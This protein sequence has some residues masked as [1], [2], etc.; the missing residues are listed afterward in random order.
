MAGER[1]ETRS[2]KGPA[3]RRRARIA[4]L[5]TALAAGVLAA[6]LLASPFILLRIGPV[7]DAALDLA[8]DQA[9]L[10]Q[11]LRLRIARVGSLDPTRVRLIGVSVERRE[12]AGDW[13]RVLGVGDLSAS[14]DPLA[15][16]RRR[17]HIHAVAIDSV[18]A[19]LAGTG[20]E[21]TADLPA[22]RRI[23]PL[24][25]A[26]HAVGLVPS[27]AVDAVELTRIAVRDSAGVFVTGGLRLG[28]LRSS[29]LGLAGEVRGGE[30]GLPRLGLEGRLGRGSLHAGR[31]G[32]LA[33]RG[34]RIELGESAAVLQAGFDPGEKDLPLSVQL[35]IEMFR[36]APWARLWPAPLSG[37]PDDYLAGSVD[38]QAGEERW[39]ALAALEGRLLGE[40][41]EELRALV[42]AEGPALELR[43]LRLRGDAGA[44]AGSGRWDL[45]SRRG[46]ARLEWERVD[47]HSAWLPWLRELPLQA[48]VGGSARVEARFPAGEDPVI[49]GEL[50]VRGADPW[51]V[52]VS[53]CR[54]AASVDPARGIEADELELRLAGGSLRGQ[55]E[56]PLDGRPVRGLV[57]VDSLDLG[58]LPAAWSGGAAGR[59]SGAVSLSGPPHA[60][61][62]LGEAQGLDLRWRDWRAD[63]L[64]VER[65]ELDLATLDGS[66]LVHAGGLREHDGPSMT[67]EA[68]GTR[69]EE[70]I[71]GELRLIHPLV[72]L[73]AAGVFGL[74][75]S[76]ALERVR[77][78]SPRYGSWELEE[79]FRADWRGG[80]IETDT[81]RVSGSLGRLDA[82][83]RW[84][85]RDG[86][87][88]LDARLRGLDLSLFNG[89][90]PESD[91]LRGLCDLRLTA[92]GRLPDP[93]LTLSAQSLRI[94]YGPVTLGRLDL[95]AGWA[96][97]TLR[98]GPVDLY[99]G[100]HALSIPELELET[101][102]PLLAWLGSAG[103]PGGARSPEGL[104]DCRWNGSLKFE[105][106]ALAGF[107]HLLG[108]LG[109]VMGDGSG[110]L[111]TTMLVSGEAVPVQ[112]ITPW[113]PV[114]KRA[115]RGS[116]GML[117]GTLALGGTPRR[118]TARLEAQAAGL[119][120]AHAELGDLVLAATYAD[121]L[122]RLD[123]FRLQA[124][125]HTTWGRG[126]YPLLL[127]LAPPA[128]RPAAGETQMHL[129]LDALD[130]SLLSG[131]SRWLPDAT[132]VLSG[133]IMLAGAAASP[134]LRGNLALNDGGLRIP[135][136]SER[137]YDARA[138]LELLPGAIRVRALDARTGPHG[139][140]T[141]VGTFTLPDQFDFTA[142]V[143]GA[144]IWEEGQYDFTANA[145]L[146]AFTTGSGPSLVPHLNGVVEVLRGTITQNLAEQEPPAQAGEAVPWV[147]DLDVDA[148]GSIH[149]SQINAKADVGR[150]RLHVAYRWPHWNVSGSLRVLGGTYR[151][152]NNTFAVREGTVDFRDTGAGPD[153]SL[154]VEAET[155][156]AVA[157][158][159]DG[160]SETVTVKV[161]VHGRPEA[162]EVELS[163]L[164]PL[165]QE[166][167]VELLSI[168]R[169]TRSGRFEAASETQWILVNTM[170]DRIETS[171]VAQSP[172]FSRVGIAAGGSGSDPLRLTWRPVVTPVFQVNYAQEL[173]LDPEMDL[174]VHYR[175]S[176]FLYLRTGVA[177]DRQAAGGYNDEYSLDLKCRFE[178]E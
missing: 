106:V 80:R 140:V 159:A 42:E 130:L 6:L 10:D 68:R 58:V 97:G 165:S 126:F 32:M 110:G 92:G 99:A 160:P 89:A 36:P 49:A 121:S 45:S 31:D 128:A 107:A 77:A 88:E 111:A 85:E 73:E 12:G 166:E 178:Y 16:L 162:L 164:P 172:L 119:R 72:D 146:N 109:G 15:L 3:P 95:T 135:Q 34:Q 51:G 167:I 157:A 104:L 82:A 98:L 127:S 144:R 23:P 177:R 153:L 40:R 52:A 120:F 150:G 115:P 132:G 18:D 4:L 137:I 102:H 70:R 94:E 100:T 39:R 142:A 103:A 71:A 66:A 2:A 24:G 176:G 151:L 65:G 149:V 134:E 113:D 118:P 163:S 53:E 59:L 122:V 114:P 108:S 168:G 86:S 30:V 5:R 20:G 55:G 50:R 158:A 112:V 75:G 35:L 125:G 131:L 105:R 64:L 156:V 60:L 90:E 46:E 76:L 84:E 37:A 7:R 13:R 143:E 136:R 8:A 93:E 26:A 47:P 21:R 169:F 170:V 129:E 161:T 87:L 27:L 74:D 152:L 78:A 9:G 44:L 173:A 171:L 145:S 123:D 138:R 63:S 91:S 96:R 79:P 56:W 69:R 25:N 14:W 147:I 154:T 148:P 155:S 11:G 17:L 101:G 175:L 19:R 33:L 61:T 1:P 29:G 174:S 117:R 124:N 54:V 116:G 43:E 139:T 141:A 28:D 83:L 133:Q 62:L 57:T 38:L 41:L 67:L 48:R 81:L 22:P